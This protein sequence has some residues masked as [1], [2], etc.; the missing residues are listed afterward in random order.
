MLDWSTGRKMEIQSMTHRMVSTLCAE[1][2]RTQDRPS[3]YALFSREKTEG[4]DRT[5]GISL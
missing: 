1:N 3:R 4:P 5:P 2:G